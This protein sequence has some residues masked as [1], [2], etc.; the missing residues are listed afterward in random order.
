[1]TRWQAMFHPDI[2]R[3]ALRDKLGA[4]P[5][6][7]Y[8]RAG[9]GFAFEGGTGRWLFVVLAAV[10]ALPLLVAR[11]RGRFERAALAWAAI[12]PGLWGLVLW[13]LVT[14][15]SIPGVRWNEAALVLVPFDLALPFLGEERRHRYARVRVVMLLAI[16]IL[17]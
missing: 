17:C 7:V 11:W 2:L 12:Y 6:L 5:Q 14:I 16:S 4:E 3:L 10:F 8:K 13:T 15:S 1:P 9:P